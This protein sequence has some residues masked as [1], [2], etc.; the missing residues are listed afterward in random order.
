MYHSTPKLI[1]ISSQFDGN[2]PSRR[3]SQ[4]VINWQH[5]CFGESIWQSID[6]SV[7]KS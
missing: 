1:H 7:L 4:L 3:K 5:V 6:V 2:D